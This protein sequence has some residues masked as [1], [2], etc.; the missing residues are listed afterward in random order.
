MTEWQMVTVGQLCD[1]GEAFVQTGPFGSQLHKHDYVPAGIPVVPTEAIGRR[2]LRVGQLP[3]VSA[4]TRDRLSRHVLRA[5]DIL[6][7]RRGVQATGLSAIIEADQAGWLCG[8]G[9]ILLRVSSARV[10]SEFLSFLLSSDETVEWLKRHAVG[11]VMPNLNETVV[12]LLPLRLPSIEQQR[13]IASFLASLDQKIG[14]NAQTASTLERLAGTVFRSWFID[15]DPV[16]AKSEGR[17]PFGMDADTA[18]LFPSRFVESELGPIPEGWRVDRVRAVVEFAYGKSLKADARRFG[19]VPV[20]GS[21]GVTGW[22]DEALVEGPGIVV[23]RKG[24][25]GR[26]NWSEGSFYPIDTTFFVRSRD[27]RYALRFLF[28][29]LASVGLEELSGDSAVP[30]LN[31]DLAYTAEVIVPPAEFAH[32]YAIF[33]EPLQRLIAANTAENRT[34]SELRDT[35]F[36]KFMSGEIRLKQAEKAV[37]AAV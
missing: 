35:L 3:R 6:F 1:A 18:A 21:D 10:D 11:A 5:G 20:F 17:Q 26:V 29:L 8:T 12:R 25:A 7:A 16:V 24:N 9:A 34:L 15:Y 13:E 32:A 33:A 2:T 37:E 19:A 36:P 28:P 31:R 4:E 14:L 23:G 22:H 30:G 27:S